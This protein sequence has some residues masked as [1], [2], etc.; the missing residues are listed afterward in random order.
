M[1]LSLN[2][3]I[4][5][6]YRGCHIIIILGNIRCRWNYVIGGYVLLGSVHKVLRRVPDHEIVLRA[7]Q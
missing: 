3:F 4:C 5:R 2:V 6:C 7:T 1:K